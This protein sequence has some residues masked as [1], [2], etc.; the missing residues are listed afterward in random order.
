MLKRLSYSVLSGLLL[1]IAWADWSPALLII[2]AFVPLLL[3]ENEL[4]EERNT[5]HSILAFYYSFLAFFLW[6]L[7]AIWW[8]VLATPVGMVVVIT[9]NSVFMATVFWLFHCSKRLLG[10]KTGNFLYLIYWMGFEYLHLNWEFSWSWLNLGNVFGKSTHLIQWY[11]FTGTLGGTLWVL[12]INLILAVGINKFLQNHN[13]KLMLPNGIALLLVLVFPPGFSHYLYSTYHEKEAI[14]RVVLIQPNIDTYSQKFDELGQDKQLDLILKLAKEKAHKS[15]DYFIAPETA[16]IKPVWEEIPLSSKSI[17]RVVEFLQN[18]PNSEFIIGAVTQKMYSKEMD[19]PLTARK[20][21]NAGMYYDIFNSAL[22]I[23]ADG[24]W[25]IYHKS[26]LILGVEKMPFPGSLGF[27][28]NLAVDLGGV[29]GS[30]GSQP[31]REVFASKN[32]SAKI[33]P[34]IC[35]ESVFGDYMNDYVRLGANIIFVITN[36]GWWEKTSGYFQH[37]RYSKL[38]AI[39]TRRSIARCGNTG[40]TGIID[41]RGKFVQNLPYWE[42]AVLEGTVALHENVTF[43]TKNGDYLGRIFSFLAVLGLLY[44]LVAKLK[45]EY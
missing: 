4:Y 5:N 20:I 14:C 9:L 6:N 40:I 29:N 7:W 35:Y 43:Y 37:T 38:R 31:N 45:Q 24:S 26:Q 41:C 11:E 25:K 23:S 28:E 10:V 19:I 21:G 2:V 27:L 22:Q 39:E 12:V 3:L 44:A 42:P 17:K 32:T 1:G 15:V 34:V 33:A 18:Y 13:V 16:I 36:D 8:I 30:L